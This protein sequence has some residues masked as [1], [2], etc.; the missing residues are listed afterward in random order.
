MRKHTTWGFEFLKGRY[1]FELASTIARTHHESWDGNGY[2]AGL[3]AEEIPEATLITS[4][5]DAYDAM[6]N[7]RPYRKGRPA[8]EAIEELVRFSGR[9]FSPKV[10]DAA[11]RLYERGVAPFV[12]L[13]KKEAAA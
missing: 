10:V 9:Q 2:P 12:D 7:D 8:I 1:G 6:T 3:R 5:A 4:V 11:V 13:P